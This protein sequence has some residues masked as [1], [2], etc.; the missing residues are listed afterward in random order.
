MNKKKEWKI[1][2]VMVLASLVLDLT[3]FTFYAV[4]G[5]SRFERSSLT[6]LYGF[7]VIIED[8]RPEIEKDGLKKEQIRKDIE[9]Q[10]LKA[11]IRVLT[12]E[13]QMK[14]P[15][16]PVLQVIVSVLKSKSY[17]CYVFH[18]FMSLTQWVSLERNPAIKAPAATWHFGSTGIIDYKK[19][20]N[21]RNEV[22]EELARF[23]NAYLSVN[24]K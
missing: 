3:I 22:K 18:I 9:S 15:G 21:I 5:D 1:S 17:G 14:T 11:G 4:A 20:N 16:G 23:I 6:G 7:H 2:L 13:E 19:L 8:L 10:L 12:E 24:N